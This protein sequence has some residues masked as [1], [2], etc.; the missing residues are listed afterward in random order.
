M[1]DSPINQATL[2][3]LIQ[4]TDADF[5]KDIIDTF[6]DDTP[7]MLG[8]MRQA[9]TT[10]DAEAFRRAAH[11]LKSNSASFGAM[12]LSG[13]AKEMEMLGKVGNLAGVSDR[14]TEMAAEFDRVQVVLREWQH[15]AK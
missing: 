9:L 3:E 10:N 11:S 4:S 12:R 7:K 14:L 15:G 13:Q 6:L 8:E 2:N 1:S 5:V